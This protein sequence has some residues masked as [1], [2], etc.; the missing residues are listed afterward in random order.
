MSVQ[1]IPEG[2]HTVTPYIPVKGARAFIDFL[3]KAFHAE[4]IE[5]TTGEDGSI[6]NA[7]IR[8]GS[9]MIMA[10]DARDHVP[11]PCTLYMY[12]VDPDKVYQQAIGTGAKSICPMTD[13]FYGDRAGG[14]ED[15][16]G[17]QW[18]IAKRMH[19]VS[20]DEVARVQEQSRK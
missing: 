16:W 19:R 9:S 18:W 10:A 17:N 5:V 7:E 3:K 8:I 1:P 11:R 2:Y 6:Y 15:A 13:Q 12:V 20:P 4:E 14:V